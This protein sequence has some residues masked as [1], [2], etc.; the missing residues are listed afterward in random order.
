L[1]RAA[2]PAAAGAGQDAEEVVDGSY[3]GEIDEDDDEYELMD[4]EI[5]AIVE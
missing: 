5:E 1:R 4:D 2:G 3:V